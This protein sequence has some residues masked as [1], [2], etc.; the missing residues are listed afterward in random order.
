MNF[1]HRLP[2]RNRRTD[3]H[4]IPHQ[5]DEYL[6]Q[7]KLV[8]GSFQIPNSISAREEASKANPALTLHWEKY[9]SFVCCIIICLFVAL[10]KA[11]YAET[12]HIVLLSCRN[13]KSVHIQPLVCLYVHY[14]VPPTEG[15]GGGGEGGGGGGGVSNPGL[16]VTSPT[17]YHW[18]ASFDRRRPTSLWI[19]SL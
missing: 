5:K 16:R 10:L 14:P 4:T 8:F 19:V 13:K 6:S 2:S 7:W 9:S 11:S 18:A 3:R 12:S 17:L 1:G 15:E